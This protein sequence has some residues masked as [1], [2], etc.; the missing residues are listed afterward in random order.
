MC[1]IPNE[2]QP[3][4]NWFKDRFNS[5]IA[6]VVAVNEKKEEAYRERGLSQRVA[7]R[8][9]LPT[10]IVWEAAA[11]V[12]LVKSV[13]ENSAATT[14]STVPHWT[15]VRPCAVRTASSL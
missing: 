9:V 3:T 2:A 13:S 4:A 5:V 8:A 12:P 6:N 7:I 10:R 15:A 14:I 11:A 1:R